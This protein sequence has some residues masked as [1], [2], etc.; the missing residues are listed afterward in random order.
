MN[1]Y[2]T[3]YKRYIRSSNY[4]IWY[5]SEERGWLFIASSY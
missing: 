2:I 1:T 5:Y 3:E 4:A